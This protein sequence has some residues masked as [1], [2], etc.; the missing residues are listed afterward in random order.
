MIGN[1]E[2][3]ASVPAL[4]TG[5]VSLETAGF[6][7]LGLGVALLVADAFLG[8]GFVTDFAAPLLAGAGAVLLVHEHDYDPP[9]WLTTTLTATVALFIL[10]TIVALLR[11]RQFVFKGDAAKMTGRVGLARTALAPDGLVVIKGEQWPAG[12]ARGIIR[13]GEP[14]KVTGSDDGRLLVDVHRPPP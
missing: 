3:R 2:E 5:I 12:A 13:E 10:T 8:L 14:V 7:L 1:G 11:T 6:I 9:A 4:Y